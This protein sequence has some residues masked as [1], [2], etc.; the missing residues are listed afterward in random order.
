MPTIDLTEDGLAAETAAIRRLVDEDRSPT[1][2]AS[3]RCAPPSQSSTPR[4]S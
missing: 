4:Q 3:T 1:R 2:H